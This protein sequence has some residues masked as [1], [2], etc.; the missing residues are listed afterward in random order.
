LTTLI[1]NFGDNKENWMW[2]KNGKKM[3]RQAAARAE[4][5]TTMGYCLIKESSSFLLG[6][7]SIYFAL[8]MYDMFEICIRVQ[9]AKLRYAPC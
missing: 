2:K 7:S 1:F 4:E 9:M 5:A 3:S 8:F 6:F